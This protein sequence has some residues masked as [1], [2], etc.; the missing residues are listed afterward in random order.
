M[1]ASSSKKSQQQFMSP[2]VLVASVTGRT[3][4]VPE[5]AP[6]PERVRLRPTEGQV[7]VATAMAQEIDD[8]KRYRDDFGKRAP[9]PGVLGSLLVRARALSDEV[10]RAEAWHAY[11]KGEAAAA[12]QQALEQAGRL[13]EHYESADRADP[14][15]ALRYPNVSAFYG[16]RAEIAARGVAT[17]RRRRAEKK[18]P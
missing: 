12:W 7:R 6:P 16:E 8:P 4:G 11:L 15:I 18:N 1:T 10:A 2:M 13:Q 14:D 17:R 5:N 3:P 9:D